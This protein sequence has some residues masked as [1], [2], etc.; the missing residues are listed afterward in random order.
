MIRLYGYD[1]FLADF[2]DS[3]YPPHKIFVD[4]FGGS[5]VVILRKS[6][7][8]VEIYNDLDPSMVNYFR[9]VVDVNC[10]SSMFKILDEIVLG[11]DYLLYARS[12]INRFVDKRR[13]I[14]E[15]GLEKGLVHFDKKDLSPDPE[16]AVARFLLNLFTEGFSYPKKI[17]DKKIYNIDRETVKKLWMET[18]E[19][20]RDVVF[21][22][23]DWRQILETYDSKNT[24]FYADP[25]FPDT[26]EE[27]YIKNFE[28][29]DVIELI[30]RLEN[31]KGK[32]IIKMRY[33]TDLE[34]YIIRRQLSHMIIETKGRTKTYVKLFLI[35]NYP[36]PRDIKEGTMA[37]RPEITILRIKER[38]EIKREAEKEREDL[39]KLIMR[40]LK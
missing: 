1:I 9:C 32:Y 25:P 11:D 33:E 29:E 24:F 7:S 27:A 37:G 18:G 30:T 34:R 13:E 23:R 16:V 6:V 28:K 17:D 39:K 15:R 3:I 22:N 20:M 35:Y 10:L 4:L 5:G 14:M 19:R 31:I 8:D 12:L 36:L 2:L 40:I 38:E 21:L 26:P